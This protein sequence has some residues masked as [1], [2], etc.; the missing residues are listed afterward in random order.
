M[1]KI[2]DQP[3]HAVS[4]I[5]LSEVILITKYK[6]K[7]DSPK[8]FEAPSQKDL[9][10]IFQGLLQIARENSKCKFLQ[11]APMMRLSRLKQTTNYKLRH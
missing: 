6:L 8:I 4:E 2:P 3:F 10:T 9:N 5:Q 7:V 11:F 1:I